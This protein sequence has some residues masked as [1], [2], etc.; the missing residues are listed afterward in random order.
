[1]LYVI[2]WHELAW[3]E[4]RCENRLRKKERKKLG[5]AN[6]SQVR[7]AELQNPW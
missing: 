5:G 4:M 3:D 2:R 6:E 7:Q 1:M